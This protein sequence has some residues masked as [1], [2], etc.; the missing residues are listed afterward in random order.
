MLTPAVE[1][2][3]YPGK[4]EDIRG[5]SFWTSAQKPALRKWHRKR[6]LP[7][8]T[9][10]PVSYTHKLLE[11]GVFTPTM[12]IILVNSKGMDHF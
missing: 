8:H 10:P 6:H 1:T 4:G 3:G 12:T 11:T 9:L 5:S 7:S 2:P